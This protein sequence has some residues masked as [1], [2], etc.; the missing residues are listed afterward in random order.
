MTLD[1]ER[2][3]WSFKMSRGDCEEVTGSNG[4]IVHLTIGAFEDAIKLNVD[5]KT[6]LKYRER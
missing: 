4:I 3:K 1:F 2:G 6:R 5:Q